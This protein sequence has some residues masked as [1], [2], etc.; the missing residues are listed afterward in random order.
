VAAIAAGA[1]ASAILAGS[2]A[3]V[4]AERD[5][6]RTGMAAAWHARPGWIAAGI[7]LECL[8]MAGFVLLQRRLLTAAGGKPTASVLLAT[9]YASN[10]LA[11]G[12]PVV[13]SGLAAAT[14]LR[15]L[16]GRGLDPAAIRL[17]LGL[18][19]VISAV[20]FAAVVAAGAVLTGNPA[21]AGTGLLT[22]CGSAAAAAVLIIAAHSPAGRARLQP[23]AAR[24]L[25]LAQ[26][27]AR[28]PVGDPAVIA[29]RAISRLGSLQLGP[30]A[31]GYLLACGLVNWIA[32]A[33]CLAAAIAATGQ[34]VPW[35][36]LLLVWTAG[37]G[38][39]TLS[40]TPF[41]I[42]VVEPALIAGLA[43]AGNSTPGAIG[44]VLLYRIMTFK[45]AGLIWVAYLHLRQRTQDRSTAS[46]QQEGALVRP[47][48]GQGHAGPADAHPHLRPAAVRYPGNAAQR[49]LRGHHHLPDDAPVLSSSGSDAQLKSV[50]DLVSR[51]CQVSVLSHMQSAGG[52][53]L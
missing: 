47:R 15:Q 10:A 36:K 8:S 1:A 30:R 4:Y 50:T 34:P 49:V 13:G 5:M 52:S 19:G 22:G 53:V 7:I 21:G 43:A 24:V 38:A 37:A 23:I 35:D 41:G 48:S 9:D 39:S 32:D 11:A 14:V 20:T 27:V 18:A 51:R 45:I 16:R 40:P 25:R 44:A 6:V 26:R 28:R 12:V 3:A 29:A 31:I 42:G 2:V 33:G 17:T 46:A